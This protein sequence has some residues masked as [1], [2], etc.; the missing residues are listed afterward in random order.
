MV[1]GK[2]VC[3]VDFKCCSPLGNAEAVE[4]WDELDPPAAEE[5]G[6]HDA[7]ELPE[8]QPFENRFGL[9]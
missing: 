2:A 7:F 3:S 8:S 4:L 6:A 1:F 9:R 5:D